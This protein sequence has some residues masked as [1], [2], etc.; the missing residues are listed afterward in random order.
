MYGIIRA[1]SQELLQWLKLDYFGITKST[2]C[3][4]LG[5]S[6]YE[7]EL[8]PNFRTSHHEEKLSV[9]NQSIEHQ[10]LVKSRH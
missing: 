4:F 7:A 8:P 3:I 5:E 10:P 1:D 6:E 9:I 2:N